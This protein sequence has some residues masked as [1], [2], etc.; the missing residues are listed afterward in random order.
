MAKINFDNKNN[1]VLEV[2]RPVDHWAKIDRRIADDQRLSLAARGV[3][4]WIGSR[5]DGHRLFVGYLQDRCGISE[6]K[7]QLISKEL[8]K[9]GYYKSSR[10][11][12]EGRYIWSYKIDLVY[13]PDSD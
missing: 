6:S 9:V 7:W 11:H 12:K 4:A 1:G 5:P 8:K 3:L 2:N 13:I 10:S